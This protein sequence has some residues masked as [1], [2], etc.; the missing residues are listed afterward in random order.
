MQ[1]NNPNPDGVVAAT[2]LAEF[3]RGALRSALAGQRLAVEEHTEHYV[4]NV[5]TVFARAENLHESTADGTLAQ[6]FGE[7]LEA[8]S[9]AERDSALQ[10][11]GDVSLFMAG[12]FA[13]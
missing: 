3:F 6:M 13:R 5:L 2:N 12:L 1:S 10:R 4:V 8:A 7:A 9:A 11:L